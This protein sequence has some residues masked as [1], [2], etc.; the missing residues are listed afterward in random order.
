MRQKGE[1]IVRTY[2]IFYWFEKLVLP[3]NEILIILLVSL[4]TIFIAIRPIRNFHSLERPAP[5]KPV[6]PEKI[7]EW[8]VEPTAVTVGLYIVNF[9][10]IDFVNNSFIFDAII[11]FEFDPALLSLDTV[12]KFA[13]EKGEILQKSESSTQIVEN[14]FFARYDIRVRFKT[15]LDYTFYPFDD[16]M[17]Y[18]SLINRSVQPSEMIYR[19]Y[20]SLF[21]LSK[22]VNFS[23][24]QIYDTNVTTGYFESTLD[25][26]DKHKVVLQPK[27]VFTIYLQRAGVR[28]ILLII[29]PLFLIYILSL[30]SFSFD[31]L[32]NASTIMMLSSAGVTSLLA[33]RFVIENMTPKVGYFV[34]SDQFFI[35]LLAITLV[36]FVFN[37][38]LIQVDRLTHYLSMIRGLLFLTINLVFLIAWYSFLYNA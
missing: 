36:I 19:S 22:N 30:F 7:R 16:H 26:Y 9:P 10:E 31:P 35:L 21:K 28:N 17:V 13:F 18:F 4:I 14:K 20:T 37:V 24:W 5:I 23:G 11:W 15:D 33:Y 34:L 1:Q 6:T 12:G 3:R 29:L 2:L 27:T 8:G 32:K 25:R 38:V